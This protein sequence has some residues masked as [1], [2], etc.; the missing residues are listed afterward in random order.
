MITI[1]RIYLFSLSKSLDIFKETLESLLTHILGTTIQQEV[2]KKIL[3]NKQN[4]I[5]MRRNVI[6]CKFDKVRRIIIW[7]GICYTSNNCS[8]IIH[9]IL[10]HNITV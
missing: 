2:G 9:N 5:V 6:F 7:H 3:I 4:K 8:A 10:L 1:K